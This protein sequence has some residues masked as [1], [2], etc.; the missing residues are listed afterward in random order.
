MTKK[1][2][3][4]VIANYANN[5]QFVTSGI[6]IMPHNGV[7]IK[8]DYSYRLTGALHASLVN[9]L[10]GYNPAQHTINIGLGYSF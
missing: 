7:S 8:V 9:P 5:L 3:S 4:N 10:V 1:T 2:P 6:T